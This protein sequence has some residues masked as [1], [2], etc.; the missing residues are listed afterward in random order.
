VSTFVPEIAVLLPQ[1]FGLG[2]GRRRLPIGRARRA[3][4]D[5]VARRQR[6]Q[7]TDNASFIPA[8]IMNISKLVQGLTYPA[9]MGGCGSECQLSVRMRHRAAHLD[10][11]LVVTQALINDL[12]QEVVVGPGQE[13]DFGDKLGPHPMHAAEHERR[14]KTGRARRRGIRPGSL[15]LARC[16]RL[17]G[18]RSQV[19]RSWGELVERR[20]G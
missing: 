13:F 4:E 11:R 3:S 20:D 19:E 18:F 2:M 10:G 5:E 1:G 9:E 17:S 12:T 8:K 15:R 14:S 7:S 6:Q 16:A